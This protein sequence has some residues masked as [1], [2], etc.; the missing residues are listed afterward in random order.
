MFSLVMRFFGGKCW[1]IVEITIIGRLDCR[2]WWVQ[3]WRIPTSSEIFTASH[4]GW[5]WWL[6]RWWCNRS[7]NKHD[8]DVGTSISVS[9]IFV[10]VWPRLGEWS[11]DFAS[12]DGSQSL[13]ARLF[14][15]ETGFAF[16]GTYHDALAGG[17]SPAQKVATFLRETPPGN[18]CLSLSTLFEWRRVPHTQTLPFWERLVRKRYI[19]GQF[20]IYILLQPYLMI[21]RKLNR[22]DS[23]LQNLKLS[24]THSVTSANQKQIIAVKL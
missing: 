20:C 7:C 6:R 24:L 22:G 21:S 23:Y 9:K 2:R 16:G 18:I 11:A 13:A 19:F 1:Q 4:T 12:W 5:I 10:S 14:T 17:A 8:E 15:G 3:S